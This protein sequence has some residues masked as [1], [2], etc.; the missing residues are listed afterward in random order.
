M[1][2][3]MQLEQANSLEPKSLAGYWPH[4]E[5]RVSIGVSN[6]DEDIRLNFVEYR[7]YE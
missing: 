5:K 6:V 7:A 4:I 1:L 2:L 3:P